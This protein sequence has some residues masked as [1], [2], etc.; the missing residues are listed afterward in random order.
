MLLTVPIDLYNH[1]Y[2]VFMDKKKNIILEN[3][4]FTKII[5]SPKNITFN[6]L[7]IV[8]NFKLLNVNNNISHYKNIKCIANLV[9]S[10][11]NNM[12]LEKLFS[13]E[14][15]ILE[16]YKK[17]FDLKKNNA[18]MIRNSFF[19]GSL[20]IYEKINKNTDTFIYRISGIWE[21]ADEIGLTYKIEAIVNL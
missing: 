12:T 17:T 5:Y 4:F 18:Y 15:H 21:S 1:E 10:P 14:Y 9:N 16:N 13:F 20:K 19:N 3:S 2:I 11:E 7:F 6:T 8:L